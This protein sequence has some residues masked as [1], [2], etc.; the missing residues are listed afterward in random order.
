M[1]QLDEA[2]DDT[3]ESGKNAKKLGLDTIADICIE[4]LKRVSQKNKNNLKFKVFK[5]SPSNFN[6][7]EEFE[8]K[9]NKDLS[10]LKDSYL[11]QLGLYVDQPVLSTANAIDIVYEII[12][13]NCF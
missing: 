7:K 10:E 13:K 6:L 12:L 11:K 4:R 2:V 8:L 9:E 5:L 3:K 1:V